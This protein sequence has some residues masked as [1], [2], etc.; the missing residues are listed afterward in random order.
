MADHH[1][2]FE[3]YLAL[4]ALEGGA[5]GANAGRVADNAD[6]TAA[7]A[8]VQRGTLAT[9]LEVGALLQLR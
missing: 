4:A 9:S 7:D 2:L 6:A 3:G 8:A 5:G 1:L